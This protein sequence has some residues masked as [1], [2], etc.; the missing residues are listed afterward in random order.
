VINYDQ[1]EGYIAVKW[2]KMQIGRIYHEQNG[3]VYKPRGCDGL[4]VS[5]PFLSLRQLKQ[6]IEGG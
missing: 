6:Y 5:D 4:V 2:K 3:W 1:K